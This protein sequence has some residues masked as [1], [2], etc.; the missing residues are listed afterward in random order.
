MP[1]PY[2]LSWADAPPYHYHGGTAGQPTP[3]KEEDRR[4]LWIGGLLDWM[5]EDYLYSCFTHSPEVHAL[6]QSLAT[7]SIRFHYLL[8]NWRVTLLLLF[9]HIVYS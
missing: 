8:T 2:P 5:N 9:I 7:F 6:L 1:P 4:S 3:T